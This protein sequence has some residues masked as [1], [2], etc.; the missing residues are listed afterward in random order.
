[1]YRSISAY[2]TPVAPTISAVVTFTDVPSVAAA[3]TTDIATVAVVPVIAAIRAMNLAQHDLLEHY[4][5]NIDNTKLNIYNAITK[6]MYFYGIHPNNRSLNRILV[7]DILP[8]IILV[9]LIILLIL[10]VYYSRSGHPQHI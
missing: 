9:V 4:Q 10:L 8:Y 7:V 5:P 6:L 2:D 3:A 1:M